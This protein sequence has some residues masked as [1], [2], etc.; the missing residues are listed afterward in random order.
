MHVY[1][2][3]KECLEGDK[4]VNTNAVHLGDLGF[5]ICVLA[6]H[7]LL[8]QGAYLGQASFQLSP[9]ALCFFLRSG[10][11]GF[12]VMDKL[13]D[14]PDPLFE[15]LQLLVQSS[16]FGSA[17]RS[18]GFGIQGG[19]LLIQPLTFLSNVGLQ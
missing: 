12:L 19:L 18:I 11:E 6:C 8:I 2:L 4:G 14:R 10:H 13:C 7:Q 9:N 16:K 1:G 17:D 5:V 15:S 3:L